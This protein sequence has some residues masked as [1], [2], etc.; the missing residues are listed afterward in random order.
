VLLLHGAARKNPSGASLHSSLLGTRISTT[1]RAARGGGGHGC[2]TSMLVACLGVKQ[3]S[4]DDIA[5]ERG[6]RGGLSRGV[7]ILVQSNDYFVVYVV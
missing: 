1:W 6:S 3:Y 7:L 2:I 4:M 5:C